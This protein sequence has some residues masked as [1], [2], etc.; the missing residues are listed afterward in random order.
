MRVGIDATL[1]AQERIVGISRF[2][3]NVIQ[4]LAHIPGPERYDLFYRPR[5]LRQPRRF[6]HPDDARFRA[7]LLCFPLTLAS[8]RG[9][10]VYCS[11]YQ[12][13]PRYCGSAPIVGMLHDIVYMSLPDLGSKRTRERAQARYRDV[14]ARSTL[15]ATLSEYSKAEIVRHLGVAPE[16]IHVVPLA[17]EAS[18]A[19]QPR[20]RVAEVRRRFGLEAPYVLFAGGFARRK[21][22]AGA[23]RSFAKALPRLPSDLCLALSG[24][25]GPLEDEAMALVRDAG[26]QDRVRRLGYVPDEDYP[27]LMSG[28]LVF[29]LPTLLEGFG[30]PLLEA[31]AS[32]APVL[33]ASTTSVP[34]V[35]GDA[36]VLVDPEDDAALAD[37]LVSLV[38]DAPRREE[39]RRRGFERAAQFS[40]RSAAEILLSVCRKAA[41]EG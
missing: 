30:L 27:A 2:V 35:C 23:V 40:W 19:P 6:W 22:A 33:S 11:T 13:L 4:E 3:V 10:D 34:E 7:R 16:R 14:A 1:A 15:V 26:M 17:A 41:T 37:A 8:F 25:G 31:M 36:A 28:C 5:A 21:N 29:F 9:L 18:Y 39:L 12:W 20:E 32:G 38:G 24:A